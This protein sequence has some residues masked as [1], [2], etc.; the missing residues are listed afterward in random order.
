MLI[1]NIEIV[2]A[3]T[4]ILFLLPIIY[5]LFKFNSFRIHSLASVVKAFNWGLLVQTIV[6]LFL[7]T[8]SWIKDRIIYSKGSSYF[9][10]MFG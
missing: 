3:V 9:F 1:G 10:L 5:F 6:G 2:T 8:S 4:I 7:L